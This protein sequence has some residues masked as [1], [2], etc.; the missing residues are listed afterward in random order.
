MRYR[1]V[2][3]WL[4]FLSIFA[5]TP[6]RLDPHLT[7][8]FLTT[9]ACI[10]ISTSCAKKV[11]WLSPLSQGGAR[12]LWIQS[13]Q[14][15]FSQVL[16]LLEQMHFYTPSPIVS[17]RCVFPRHISSSANGWRVSKNTNR[18]FYS[19]LGA[20]LTVEIKFSNPQVLGHHLFHIPLVLRYLHSG[21]ST[22]GSSAPL[23]RGAP[24]LRSKEDSFTAT[25]CFQ[26]F[27]E[28][29]IWT[30]MEIFIFDVFSLFA[31]RWDKV[32]IFSNI[33]TFATPSFGLF[34]SV[35]W[36]SRQPFLRLRI[37]R[38]VFLLF[39]LLDISDFCDFSHISVF[40]LL[41][42]ELLWGI[43]FR[44][45]LKFLCFRTE[46]G[47]STLVCSIT[48]CKRSSFFAKNRILLARSFPRRSVN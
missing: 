36:K 13:L 28:R 2:W 44:M 33:F 41:F 34:V 23:L 10:K 32:H 43:T 7:P 16:C 18:T 20:T 1:I 42:H 35:L 6:V 15:L 25:F 26:S 9:N 47:S 39:C 17:E 14:S 40:E 19:V 4:R 31:L 46:L 22:F 3:V 29:A 5:Y 21:V 24:F 48:L 12:Y 27:A 38:D 8:V 30:A 45:A 37:C 11:D